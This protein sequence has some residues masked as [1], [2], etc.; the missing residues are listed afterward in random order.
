MGG[1]GGC[2]DYWL[3]DVAVII[4]WETLQRLLVG[5]RCSD[6]W[7]GDVAAIIGWETLQRLLVG[8]RCIA[9]SLQGGWGGDCAG[10]AYRLSPIA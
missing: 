5:R 8:R 4:G 7:L 2:G 10:F 6:Y 1:Y 3:G 9:T